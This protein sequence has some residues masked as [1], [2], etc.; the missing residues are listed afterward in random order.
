MT[1]KPV[2]IAFVGDLMLGRQVSAAAATHAP[3]SFWGDTLPM[4]RAADAVMGNLESPITARGREWRR[5]WKAFRF[6]ADPRVVEL[7][8]AGNL[9]FVSLANNHMLDQEGEGLLDTLAHLD[10][11]GIAHA[12]AGRNSAEALRPAL[13]DIGGLRVGVLSLTDNMPEF[14]AG[15]DRPGT[16]YIRIRTDHATLGLIALLVGGLR[17]AGAALI[18]LSAHWG[19][20]LRPWPPARF[21]AFARAVVDLGVD[22]FHGH[23]AHLLQG[24]ELRS[25]R[26]ILY[27][28]GDFLDDYW[29]FPFVRTDRSCLFLGEFVDGRLAHLRIVPVIL[30]PGQVHRAMGDEGHRIVSGL[31]A[32]CAALRGASIDIV[33]EL[34]VRGPLS[35][36]AHAAFESLGATARRSSTIRLVPNVAG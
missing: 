26:L 22:V 14:A 36:P 16:N 6:R 3:E 5:C 4:L 34:H 7:L 28:T 12:G 35:T 19:P 15:P 30:T 17:R 21:R 29:V 8:K 32:H 27:D 11:A 25:G 1:A 18:V 13:F 31:L 9:R 20:N 10:A 33:P 23:S 24:F 2:T